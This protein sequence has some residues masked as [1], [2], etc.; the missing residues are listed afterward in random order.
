MLFILQGRISLNVFRWVTVAAIGFLTGLVSVLYVL[1]VSITFMCTLYIHLCV[2]VRV[3]V[4]VCVRVC[5]NTCLCEY[6]VYM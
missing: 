3:C 2:C 1:H 6:I 4:H 5:V